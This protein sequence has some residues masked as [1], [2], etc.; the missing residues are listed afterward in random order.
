MAR[1]RSSV[2]HQAALDATVDVLLEAGAEGVTL[3]EVA[4]R[5]GVARSTLY[6]HFG[7]KEA[8]FDECVKRYL[9]TYAQVTECLWDESLLPR[10]AVET[11]LRQSARRAINSSR[12]SQRARRMPS[13]S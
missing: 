7:S 6:R 12:D 5:S 3:E 1:P 9:A 11:A 13:S 8:L 10:Q 4:A 2:A